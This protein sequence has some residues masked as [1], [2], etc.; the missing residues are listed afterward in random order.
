MFGNVDKKPTKYACWCVC[1]VTYFYIKLASSCDSA[2]KVLIQIKISQYV[3]PGNYIPS[4][5][6]SSK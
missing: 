2:R 6:V 5:Q 1:K 3:I 4:F